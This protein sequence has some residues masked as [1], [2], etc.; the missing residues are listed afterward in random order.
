[1]HIKLHHVDRKYLTLYAY[2]TPRQVTQLGG[3]TTAGF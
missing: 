1:M 2:V 3:L